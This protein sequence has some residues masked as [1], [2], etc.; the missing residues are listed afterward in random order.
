MSGVL[1]PGQ[2]FA[3]DFQVERLLSQGGMGA[4]YVAR[5]LSTNKLRALKLMHAQFVPDARSRQRFV[6]EARIGGLIDSEHIVEVV[7]AGIDEASGAPWLAMELL[8]G[9]DVASLM[10]SRGVLSAPQVRTLFEQ[11]GHA[12]QAAHARGIVHRDLKPENLFVARARRQGVASVLK[13][14]DFGIATAVPQG[15]VGRMT[16]AMGSPLWMAPEQARRGEVVAP[17]T[18]VWALG[19]IAFHLLTG[20]YYW[21]AANGVE[22]GPAEVLA[23]ILVEP[24]VAASARAQEVSAP[25][26]LPSGFDAWFSRCVNRDAAAR[27]ADAGAAVGALLALLGPL[28]EPVIPDASPGAIEPVVSSD[29]LDATHARRPQATP[30][31]AEPTRPSVAAEASRRAASLSAQQPDGRA[32]PHAASA[33]SLK[34]T[35]NIATPNAATPNAATPNTATPNAATPN[36]ATPN[37]AT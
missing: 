25:A 16:T 3:R 29:P 36:A 23:E 34:P 37:A 18:D 27:F 1:E 32:T 8:D 17:T 33:P 4:V 7:A 14:L 2:L 31:W 9:Q 5:Q 6:E 21:H 15:G 24:L 22:S 26:V 19:L 12:L 30:E 28:A 11:V 13:V 35:P 20:R 10:A